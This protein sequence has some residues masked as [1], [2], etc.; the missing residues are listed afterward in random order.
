MAIAIAISA[1]AFA[2]FCVWLAV[3][4]FNRRERWAKRTLAASLFG[5]LAGYPLSYG[6][7]LWLFTKF[8]Q[9]PVASRVIVAFYRPLWVAASV[10]ETTAGLLNWYVHLWI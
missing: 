9:S 2:A 3:R 5:I 1:I 8:S 10:S 6:P 7:V 4:I